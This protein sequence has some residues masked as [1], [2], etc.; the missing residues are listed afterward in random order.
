MYHCLKK[1]QKFKITCFVA[2]AFACLYFFFN[3]HQQDDIDYETCGF[4]IISLGACDEN[5]IHTNGHTNDNNNNN[6]HSKKKVDSL[7]LHHPLTVAVDRNE[8]IIVI[9]NMSPDTNK[10][11]KNVHFRLINF[12]FD[13][14]INFYIPL[15]PMRPVDVTIDFHNNYYITSNTL[16]KKYR[17]TELIF[18]FVP[19]YNANTMHL[20]Q[21]CS[22]QFNSDQENLFLLDEANVCIQ[23][24]GSELG[25][26]QTTID[27][28]EFVVK[29][30]KLYIQ[31]KSTLIVTDKAID[32]VVICQ[33]NKNS[34]LQSKSNGSQ[35]IG[36]GEF[37]SP[38]ATTTD[39]S[40]N[41]L[42]CDSGNHR[43]CVLHAVSGDYRTCIG[44]LGDGL[45]SLKSPS[46][47]CLHYFDGCYG[48]RRKEVDGL[49]MLIADKLNNRIVV[50]SL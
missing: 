21:I 33:Y 43:V 10:N 46:D 18:Q 37:V 23:V 4:N 5:T 44:Q 20:P 24:F 22:I 1:W 39:Q 25:Q 49:K 36:H 19:Y 45:R 15:H 3:S 2:L 48:R 7:K 28:S 34:I 11:K 50:Y 40:G 8:D 6:N 47:V 42:V 16:V 27:L 29:P 12:T 41:I 31:N 26:Y 30:S 17:R 9:D 14:E 38:T 13:G 32:S 35:G